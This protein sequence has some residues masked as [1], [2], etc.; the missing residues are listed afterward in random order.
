LFVVALF[1]GNDLEEYTRLPPPRWSDWMDRRNSMLYVTGLRLWAVGLE[2]ARSGADA[3]EIARGLGR[4][5]AAGL[6]T[7]E[8]ERELPHLVD[9]LLERASYS[10]ERFMQ[11]EVQRAQLL[12]R[13]SEA[14]YARLGRQLDDLRSAAG[15]VPLALVVIPDEFQVDDVLWAG[16]LAG[17]GDEPLERERFQAF[18]RDWGAARGVPVCDLLP[19][20]RAVPPWSDGRPHLYHLRDTHFNARG[21]RAAGESVARFLAGILPSPSGVSER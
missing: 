9:P 10:P 5:L 8:L 12:G 19:D 3:D 13:P 15:D 6:D 21:N 20:L 14:E 1:A 16:V 11:L 7:S 4:G 18:V 17:V 2:R